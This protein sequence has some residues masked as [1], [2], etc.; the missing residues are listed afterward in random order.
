MEGAEIPFQWIGG[1]IRVDWCDECDN[2]AGGLKHIRLADTALTRYISQIVGDVK[3][4]KHVHDHQ[5]TYIRAT[6]MV[7]VHFL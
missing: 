4:W 6:H 7:R 5:L 1:T 3:V 2:L